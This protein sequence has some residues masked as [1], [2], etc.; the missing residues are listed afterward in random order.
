M[1]YY[2]LSICLDEPSVDYTESSSITVNNIS[3]KDCL[4]KAFGIMAPKTIVDHVCLT[5]MAE[6]G[7]GRIVYQ[8]SWNFNATEFKHYI[9]GNF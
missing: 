2:T 3:V 9:E 4:E 1:T 8:N 7:D 6:A 5:L